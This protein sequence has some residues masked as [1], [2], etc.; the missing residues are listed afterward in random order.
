MAASMFII[1]RLCDYDQAR[2]VTYRNWRTPKRKAAAAA[3]AA[4]PAQARKPSA[5]FLRGLRSAG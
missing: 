3:A 1:A 4:A 2:H 5:A